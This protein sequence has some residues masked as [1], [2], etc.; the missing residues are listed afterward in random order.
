MANI[1]DRIIDNK[2]REVEAK[3][4]DGLYD[5]MYEKGLPGRVNP[6]S[7]S[8][9]LT[10]DA[11]GIIAE[12]K[13]CSPSKGAIQPMAIVSEI[14]S[15]YQ[16][17]GAA[18]CS[19]LTDTPFFGGS[20]DDFAQARICAPS[21]PL[22][23]KEFIVD[24]AQIYE[25]AFYGA[26]AIL[27]I[28]S[29]LTRDRIAEFTDFAHSLSLEVLLELHG[30]GELDKV[31]E[32]ADMIGVNNRNLTNF[33]TDT[34]MSDVMARNLPEGMV[35]VAESGLT[36]ISELRRLRD[37]GYRGFLIGETFMRH[38]NPGEAL[39]KFIDGTI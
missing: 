18:C 35:K 3:Y 14:V 16:A 22:L 39:K 19:V 10:E 9:A 17:N 28:A 38:S 37:N 6:I 27:L 30:I 5:A 23:R 31:T 29:A 32:A 2:K 34:S 15:G 24:K 12:F 1:L 36:D 20:L 26:N 25:A 33:V 7:F 8:R 21:L 11:Y 4:A 13:R